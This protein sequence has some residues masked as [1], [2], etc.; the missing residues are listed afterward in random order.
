MGETYASTSVGLVGIMHEQGIP[1]IAEAIFQWVSGLQT[2]YWH[3]TEGAD[4]RLSGDDWLEQDR[5][6]YTKSVAG[7]T[8]VSISNI[9]GLVVWNMGFPVDIDTTQWQEA[10]IGGNGLS[11]WLWVLGIH[12]GRPPFSGGIIEMIVTGQH[13]PWEV[14]LGIV[15]IITLGR[16]GLFQLLFRPETS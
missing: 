2:L 3:I 14:K 7:I 13:L 9:Q 16:G 15:R 10:R 1:C 12:W 11:T 5:S 8:H 4:G 6:T